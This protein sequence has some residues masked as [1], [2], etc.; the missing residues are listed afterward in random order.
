MWVC[1]WMNIWSD[2]YLVKFLVFQE[3]PVLFF[4]NAHFIWY[5]VISYHCWQ[6]FK[7]VKR[8]EEHRY[9]FLVYSAF[10]WITAAGIA[11][12]ISTNKYKLGNFTKCLESAIV[13]LP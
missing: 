10:V 3:L 6:I 9:L 1:Y 13:E 4:M 12:L 2:F 5:S 8:E 7:P 11:A